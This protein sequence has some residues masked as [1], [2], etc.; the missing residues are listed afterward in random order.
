MNKH[1]LS[2]D[3]P[4]PVMRAV[5]QRCG[6]GCIICGLAVVQYHHF[7][8]PFADATEHRAEGITLL[9][10]SCHQKAAQLSLEEIR[11]RDSDPFC[12]RQGIAR[13]FLFAS[14]DKI[15]FQ[16]GSATFKQHLIVA[17]ENEVLVGFASPEEP[18]AP[19]RLFARFEDDH[20]TLLQVI[21][22]TWFAGT[23]SFDIQATGNSLTIRRKPG[24]IALRMELLAGGQ[25]VLD[26][27]NMIYKGF[28]VT[29]EQGFFVVRT[30]K[31]GMMQMTCPNIYASLKLWSNGSASI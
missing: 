28:Q 2:R 14:R 16:I 13:D 21:A 17:Y 3:I 15:H 6:F 19:L 10:G 29:I 26:R 5:R 1:G 22:N 12:R 20:G 31:G 23:D 4:D 24:E 18:G 27:L 8:P 30:P 9:C 7:D 11:L 25:I